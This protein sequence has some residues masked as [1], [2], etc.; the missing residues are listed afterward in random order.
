MKKENIAILIT[1]VIGIISTFLPWISVNNIIYIKGINNFNSSF[2]T[3]ILLIFIL[4]Y[5]LYE[6]NIDTIDIIIPSLIILGI[7]LFSMFNLEMYVN[8]IHR[9]DSLIK[10]I[11][12]FNIKNNLSIEIGLYLNT[13]CG[14]F[15]TLFGFSFKTK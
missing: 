3:L 9:N 7:G 1:S 12:Y 11:S 6:E 2:F 4:F 13:L 15:L 10:I 5:S 8:N 14:L